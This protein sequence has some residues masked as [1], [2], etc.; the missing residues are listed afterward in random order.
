MKIPIPE[1]VGGESINVFI[2]FLREFLGYLIDYNMM[3]PEMDVYQVSAMGSALKD[4]ALKWYQHTIHLNANSDWT[5]ELAMIELKHY[6][7]K[8]VSSRDA[9]T[10]FDHLTQ[11]NRMVTELKKDL[12]Q[13][14]QQMIQMPSD[15]DMSCRFLNALRPEISRTVICYGVNSEN[16]NMEAIFEMAKS[17]EQGMFYEECQCSEHSKNKGS[18]EAMEKSTSDR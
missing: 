12:E 16:S 18:R 6:F 5:F 1:Y 10:C 9:A 2:K 17:I 7:V 13:L 4:R 15:Y 11:K 3:K 14:S 8:D